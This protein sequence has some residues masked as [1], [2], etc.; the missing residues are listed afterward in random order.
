[1]LPAKA[2]IQVSAQKLIMNL[3]VKLEG[4]W[5]IESLCM[6]LQGPL[7]FPLLQAFI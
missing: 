5:S 2:E 4:S 6:H 3:G 7:F 1:M